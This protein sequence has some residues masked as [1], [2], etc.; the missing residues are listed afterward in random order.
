MFR[1]IIISLSTFLIYSCEETSKK[2][3][4]KNSKEQIELSNSSNLDSLEI[5]KINSKYDLDKTWDTLSFTYELE[6]RLVQSNKLMSVEGDIIDVIKKDSTYYIKLLYKAQLFSNFDFYYT[7]ARFYLQINKNQ[8]NQLENRRRENH[9]KS[10]VTNYSGVFI[11]KAKSINSY[12]GKVLALVGSNE[13][14]NNSNNL[15]I[16]GDLID[17]YLF[18]Q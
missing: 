15:I 2:D 12:Y 11:C 16:E 6:E 10:F 8:L 13:Q 5:F 14:E 3:F 4:Q 1:Y 17:F 18:H 9:P 7:D